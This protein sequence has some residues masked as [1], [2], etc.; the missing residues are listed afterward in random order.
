MENIILSI[1]Q[2]KPER[3]GEKKGIKYSILKLDYQYGGY[4]KDYKSNNRS[5]RNEAITK[6]ILGFEEIEAKSGKSYKW[7]EIRSFTKKLK[8]NFR[9]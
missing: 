7:E 8:K 5:C 6:Q 4:K 3:N 9:F 1:K 2:V